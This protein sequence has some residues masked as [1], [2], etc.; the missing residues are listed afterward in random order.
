M[1]TEGFE[2]T[3]PPPLAPLFPSHLPPCGFFAFLDNVMQVHNIEDEQP[4]HRRAQC[5]AGEVKKKIFIS[6]WIFPSVCYLLNYIRGQGLK[7]AGVEGGPSHSRTRKKK[8]IESVRE[9]PNTSN[10]FQQARGKRAQ[11]EDSVTHASL[12]EITSLP[13]QTRFHLFNLL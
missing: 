1:F 4:W 3:L 11:V 2:V 5:S 7:V 10:Q 13:S 6:N 8:P 9:E 12:T